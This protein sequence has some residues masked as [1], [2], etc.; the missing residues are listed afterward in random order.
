MQILLACFWTAVL[1]SATADVFDLLDKLSN[2]VYTPLAVIN[3]IA[4]SIGHWKFVFQYFCGSIDTK[5]II[6]RG[7]ER[8]A[9]ETLNFRNR[10]GFGVSLIIFL[11]YLGILFTVSYAKI[12][13][14]LDILNI[15]YGV[16]CSVLVTIGLCSI[17]K[18]LQMN[19]GIKDSF[20]MMTFHLVIFNVY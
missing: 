4:F 7:V 1:C 8:H 17:S 20:V 19:R 2:E 10:V 18:L 16:L 9:E 14:G 6:W 5:A 3:G 15:F 11:S 12:L 13:I